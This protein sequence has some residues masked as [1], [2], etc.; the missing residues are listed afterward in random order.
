[1]LPSSIFSHFQL[2]KLTKLK[3]AETAENGMKL[4]ML[5]TAHCPLLTAHC[6]LLTAHCPLLTAHCPLLTVLC[7]LLTVLCPLLTVLCPLFTVLCP[8]FTVLCPLLLP[9][10][11]CLLLTT[12]EILVFYAEGREGRLRVGWEWAEGWEHFQPFSAFSAIFSI[13]SHFQQLP[14]FSCSVQADLPQNFFTD[15]STCQSLKLILKR[16]ALSPLSAHPQPTLGPP[17]SHPHVTLT[18]FLWL[19]ESWKMDEKAENGWKC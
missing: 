13:F 6:P 17:L 3:M 12:H 16:S 1:M 8:L 4:K 18:L 19:A 10:V 11:Y 14:C 7:P 5:F 9:K 2:T 15:N